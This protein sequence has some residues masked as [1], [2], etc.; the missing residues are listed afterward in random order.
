MP[1]T[2]G[3]QRQA[4]P[5]ASLPI[6]P[7]GA[8]TALDR[9]GAAAA[10]AARRPVAKVIVAV[11][12][13]SLAVQLTALLGTQ[14][15]NTLG[16]PGVSALPA[17]WLHW[18]A[19]FFQRIVTYGYWAHPGSQETPRLLLRA[20]FY[21]GYPLLARGVYEVLHPLGVG[22]TGAM[23]VTNQ[24]LVFPMAV[25]IYLM[26]TSL[27]GS[28]DVGLR[29]VHVLLLFP[30]AYFLLAPYSE[31]TFLTCVAGFVWALRTRRYWVAA[32]F[33]AV[34][35]ATRPVGLVLAGILLVGYLEQHRWRPSSL[36][37]RP[38]GYVTVAVSG[39]A[40]WA[41]YQWH[42]T[43]TPFYA[44]RMERLG[45][46]RSFT[47][48]LFHAIRYAFVAQPLTAGPFSSVALN[49]ITMIGL[50]VAFGVL[51]WIVW[52]RFG[53]AM[54]LMCAVFLLL[55]LATGTLFSFNRY[56][57]PLLPAFVVIA[58]WTARWRTFDF[59]Y[60]TLGAILLGL[61]LVLYTHGIWTG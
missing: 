15:L 14:Y 6:K 18:D 54:G 49:A 10:A 5:P 58:G 40:A 7:P 28:R 47:P 9:V 39:F 4:A 17:A 11:A 57:L 1:S 42:Y 31:A 53:I 44:E 22:V 46:N 52:K 61:F 30:F 32:A 45:W 8:R 56:V 33:A 24:V 41:A 29:T 13:W 20:A 43:G 19:V 2:L 26:G 38:L 36:A 16:H 55:S 59:V 60:K 23:L 48:N 21:P 35:G 25:L 3:P 12:A 37:L 51:S 27:T 34:A 50:L